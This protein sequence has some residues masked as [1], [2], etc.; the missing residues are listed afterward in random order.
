MTI[1]AVV[2][3]TP[4]EGETF[5]PQ[6]PVYFGVRDADSRVNPNT[7]FAFATFSKTIFD[8]SVPETQLPL[9]A[10]F[11]F[12]VFSDYIPVPATSARADLVIGDSTEGGRDVLIIASGDSTKRSSTLFVHA[13]ATMSAPLGAEFRFAVPSTPAR[14]VAT[15]Y[16]DDNPDFCGV[17]FGFVHWQR[18][19][20]VFIFCS[21]DGSGNKFVRITGP[22]T[23]SGRP[24]S[25]DAPVDWS[26]PDKSFRIFFDASNYIGRAIVTVTDETTFEET[27]IF[28][29]QISALGLLIATARMGFIERETAGNGVTAFIGIDQ[30]RAAA[31]ELYRLTL[32]THGEVLV[33]AARVD[34]SQTGTA[35]ASCVLTGAVRA[36]VAS[37]RRDRV[38]WL[39]GTER[40]IFQAAQTTD[41]RLRTVEPELAPG[42]WMVF[43]QGRP[44]QQTH[45]GSYNTGMGFDISDGNVIS[46]FRFLN[47]GATTFGVFTDAAGTGNQLISDNFVDVAVSW[48]LDSQQVLLFSDGTSIYS[49]ISATAGMVTELCPVPTVL[50]DPLSLPRFDIGLLDQAVGIAEGNG[51][52]YGGFFVLDRFVFAPIDEVLFGDITSWTLVGTPATVASSTQ[53]RPVSGLPQSF[54]YKTFPFT[55]YDRT[56]NG[57]VLILRAAVG[58]VTDH[59]GQVNPVRV[60][61]PALM[62]IDSGGSAGTLDVFIQLQ[63]V[64]SDDGS[65]TFAFVSQDAQDYKEVLNPTSELGRLISTSIDKNTPHYYMLALQ[66]GKGLRLFVDFEEQP[67]IFIPWELI[68]VALRASTDDLLSGTT[69]AVGSIPTLK[70]GTRYNF[71]DVDISMVG[72]GAGSGYDFAVTLAA[73]SDVIEDK[74]YGAAANLFFDVSDVT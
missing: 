69:V 66:P 36:D 41:S 48:D 1:P 12:D 67:R 18:N 20:G 39:S 13:E 14:G 31:L 47:D 16:Q 2:N 65:E 33:S 25:V 24:M 27:K 55:E 32:E 63:F 21:E 30:H 23:T 35:E 72:V 46:R 15:P 73:P 43:F 3:V 42:K 53:I 38:T 5:S 7:A 17:L 58:D 6:T 4:T 49:S 54:Y 29:Q 11:V 70:S 51:I 10:P 60:P 57:I 26:D 61:S 56:R 28:D 64:T 40:L 44:D 52:L 62:S 19:T 37:M 68:S 74:I 22:L 59:F 34:S 8:P 9:D 45:P 71:M 50:A